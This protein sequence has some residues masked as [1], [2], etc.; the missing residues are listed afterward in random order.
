MKQLHKYQ[1]TIVGN[2]L[3]ITL[4]FL[5]THQP[6]ANWDGNPRGHVVVIKY[7]V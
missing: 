1:N 2:P 5:L 7:F 3:L 6:L 4:W